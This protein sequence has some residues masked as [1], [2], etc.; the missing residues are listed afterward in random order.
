MGSEFGIFGGFGWVRSSVLVGELGF[1][2][3]RS[4]TSRVRSS[5]KLEVFSKMFIV[6]GFVGSEFGIFVGFGWV[7]SS[8]LVGELGFGKVRSST[9][10]VRSS[11]EFVTFGFDPTLVKT[12][13]LFCLL[14]LFNECQAKFNLSRSAVVCWCL[15]FYCGDS[16][17][18]VLSSL[19]K[20]GTSGKNKERF[21]SQEETRKKR[22]VLTCHFTR[23]FDI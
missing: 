13:S 14:L 7:R 18:S 16:Q 22:L 19:I 5:S 12:E 20:V 23:F 17:I 15:I 11:S 1:G 6:V 3:V 4:S 8:V 9:S 2:R 21:L 10:R